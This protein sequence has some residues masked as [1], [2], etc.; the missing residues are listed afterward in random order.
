VS[1]LL[2]M[3]EQTIKIRHFIQQQ[4]RYEYGYISHAFCAAVKSI[5]HDL[6]ILICQLEFLLN[7]GKLSLQ[8]FIFL[9]QQS[10]ITVQILDKILVHLKDK[11]GG[12]LINELYLYYLQ[13]GDEKYSKKIYEFLLEKSFQPFLKIL[14]TWIFR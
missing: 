9:L 14:S 7:D 5:I 6:D 1:Q 2:T 12:N 8:K 11:N 13:Q 3:C 4:S 10:K